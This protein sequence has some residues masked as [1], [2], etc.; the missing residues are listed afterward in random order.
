[1]KS[2][3]RNLICI[4]FFLQINSKEGYITK[5]GDIFKVSEIMILLIW[6]MWSS[7]EL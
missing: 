3:L 7:I 6:E 1:M 5:L 4:L 2:E